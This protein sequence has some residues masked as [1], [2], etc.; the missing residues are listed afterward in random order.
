MKIHDGKENRVILENLTP[1]QPYHLK[2]TGIM[3]VSKRR[4]QLDE[5][6]FWTKSDE[7]K[8]SLGQ[9]GPNWIN[10]VYTETAATSVELKMGLAK[11]EKPKITIN[12][13][14]RYANISGLLSSTNYEFILTPF[15]NEVRGKESYFSAKTAPPAT[16]TAAKK[17]TTKL[18]TTTTTV[19]TTTV[20]T[21]QSTITTLTTTTKTA[22]IPTTTPPSTASVTTEVVKIATTVKTMV[23]VPDIAPVV[24]ST[25]K[26]ISSTT[27][28]T[29]TTTTTTTSTI[30]TTTTTTT[31]DDG[32]TEVL[33]DNTDQVTDTPDGTTTKKEP[34]GSPVDDTIE[35]PEETAQISEP[36]VQLEP[37]KP[38]VTLPE[39]K[40]EISKISVTEKIQEIVEPEIVVPEMVVVSHAVVSS[41]TENS[42]KI[43]DRR[44]VKDE[45][46]I[47]FYESEI[48]WNKICQSRE[49]YKNVELTRVCDA[50]RSVVTQKPDFELNRIER[51]SPQIP[52]G[53]PEPGQTITGKYI[54]LRRENDF[55]LCRISIFNKKCFNFSPKFNVSPKFQFFAKISIFRQNFNFSPKFQFF[56]KISFFE[57]ILICAQNFNFPPIFHQKLQWFF[58]KKSPLS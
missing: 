18:T 24:F 54:I 47:Q 20:A 42:D 55:N 17:S 19:A 4:Y 21:T 27:K 14:N 16:T 7:L 30:K 8:I 3:R 52:L 13:Q 25:K 26:A 15:Y 23:I 36:E 53:A 48:D 10:L 11:L 50:F 2:I 6:Q 31:A 22:T 38:E 44:K 40:I 51:S 41:K 29:T 5:I 56:A 46:A 35:E 49:R 37:V 34:T 9:S 45:V 28:K 39:D 1:S 58:R 43:S 12:H 33:E 57:K 32:D